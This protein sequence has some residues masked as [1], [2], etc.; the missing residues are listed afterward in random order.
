MRKLWFDCDGYLVRVYMPGVIGDSPTVLQR[1]M[2]IVN[3]E[4]EDSFVDIMKEFPDISKALN[5]LLDLLRHSNIRWASGINWAADT[6]HSIHIQL[7]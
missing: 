4:P 3:G 2:N 7:E 5:S 1:I 6:G